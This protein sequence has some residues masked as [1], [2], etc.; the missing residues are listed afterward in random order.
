M[1]EMNKTEL[2]YE[3]GDGVGECPVIYN[4]D[5]SDEK[6]VSCYCGDA[7]HLDDV[8][9]A[10]YITGE[11][12]CLECVENGA[13]EDGKKCK[14][15]GCWNTYA[16]FADTIDGKFVLTD[17]C[18]GCYV[19]ENWEMSFEDKEYAGLTILQKINKK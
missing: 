19:D 8:E 9:M 2:C 3:C 6:I 13:N 18:K 1:T 16:H 17:E 4:D 5:C 12:Y 10:D 11:F 14:K 15:C 7:L